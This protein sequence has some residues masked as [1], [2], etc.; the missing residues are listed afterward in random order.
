MEAVVR[1][2]RGDR[3]RILL[4]ITGHDD[5][6]MPGHETEGHGMPAAMAEVAPPFTTV[7]LDVTGM[8]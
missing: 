3:G 7:A 1:S 5:L 6:D 2:G 8:T 4:Q